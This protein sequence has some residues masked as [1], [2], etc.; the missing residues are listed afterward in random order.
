MASPRDTDDRPASHRQQHSNQ[1]DA[2]DDEQEQMMDPNLYGLS[3]FHRQEH[4]QHH[5]PQ[6]QFHNRFTTDDQQQQRHHTQHTPSGSGFTSSHLPLD[7]PGGAWHTVIA[8]GQQDAPHIYS[9]SAA[10]GLG[11]HAYSTTRLM[12][13][14]VVDEDG[15]SMAG[16]E[17][18]AAGHEH[19]ESVT[20]PNLPAQGS[21]VPHH[22]HHHHNIFNIAH[23]KNGKDGKIE[24]F[25]DQEPIRLKH[26][27]KRPVIRQWLYQ[28]KLYRE[29]DQRVCSRFELFFDLLFVGLI[30]QLAGE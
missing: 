29:E 13:G 21:N 12:S 5:H 4:H 27:F 23:G 26:L 7:S 22:H 14:H 24:H 30:H 17:K 28:G 20:D 3:G 19:R 18:A 11:A 16:T 15:Q 9:N 2:Y 6:H 10:G 1:D 8:A 25:S